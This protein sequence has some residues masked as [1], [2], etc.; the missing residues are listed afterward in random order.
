[1]ATAPTSDFGRYV[2]PDDERLAAWRRVYER[3]LIVD[4][5]YPEIS[6]R[7]VDH[8][9]RRFAELGGGR[10]PIAALASAEGVSTVVVDLDETMLAETCRPAVRGDLAAL[11]FATGSVDAAAA[12]NCLYFLADPTVGIRE[13]HRILASGGLFVAS[14]PSRWND[15]ELEGIDPRWGRPSPFDS[16][17]APELVR[18]VFANVE[19]QVWNVVAY[20]LPDEQAIRDYLHGINV[21]GW[22]AKAAAITPPLQITK[23]GAH[24]WSIR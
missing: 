7:I 22:E 24:V 17:D 11:P 18:D 21:P 15:P 19:V 6:R 8:G 20:D 13:A 14:A 2:H 4:D 12:V 16:E 9:A 3:H 1:M 5:V 23:R 10:G